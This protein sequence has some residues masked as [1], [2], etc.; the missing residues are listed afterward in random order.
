MKYTFLFKIQSKYF[1]VSDWLKAPYS[2]V[3]I[4]NE[5]PWA[6]Y[7]TYHPST[8]IPGAAAIVV[9]SRGN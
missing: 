2:I 5:A 7:H 9:C 1:T 4:G 3:L 8:A 6:T